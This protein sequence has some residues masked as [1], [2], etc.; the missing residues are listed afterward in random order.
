MSAFK[1]L[2]DVCNNFEADLR[3]SSKELFS[4]NI[5]DA[6]EDVIAKKMRDLSLFTSKLRLLR[7]NPISMTPQITEHEKTKETILN[8]Y[9]ETAST[10]VL[11]QQIVKFLTQSH[12]VKALITSPN[13]K[14]QPE[15]IERKEKILE[16]MKTYQQKESQL[17]HMDVLLK[18]KEDQ[19]TAV[20]VQWDHELGLMKDMSDKIEDTDDEEPGPLHMKLRKLV[21]KL[22]L[23][24][25]LLGKLV[26]SRTGSYDWLADPHSRINALKIARTVNTVDTFTT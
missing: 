8:S 1:M 17:R 5:G 26:T 3:Q 11:E 19:L 16:A 13:S 15:M 24:R 23:M 14:L 21:D 9:S 20:R 10:K 4:A 25:W 7:G 2:R 18:E 22:E 6:S 12:A